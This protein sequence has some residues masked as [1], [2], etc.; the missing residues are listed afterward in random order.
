M[1]VASWLV[2]SP[3]HAQEATDAARL[4]REGWR[5]YRDKQYAEACPLL[6]RSVAAAPKVRARGALALCYQDSGRLATAYQTW[7]VVAGEARAA[8]AAEAASLRLA[9]RAIAR[10]APRLTRAEL[11]VVDA[12][13]QLRV[14]LDGQ[15]LAAAD[16][17]APIL[18]DPGLH[19]LEARAPERVDWQGS[20]E[21]TPADEGKTRS[22]PIG[23]LPPVPRVA[24]VEPAPAETAPAVTAA[25]ARRTPT[26]R[27]VGLATA[28]AGVV[29]LGV[30]TFAALSARSTWNDAKAM[31]CDDSGVCRTQAGVDLVNDASSKATLGTVF[32]SAGL[33]LAAGGA[34]LWFLTP[35]GEPVTPSVAVGPGGA[36]LVVRGSF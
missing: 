36:Q 21:V 11:E 5:L 15:E 6:E 23:P 13:P 16:L 31:G 20:F 12:P 28:G 7:Q 1:S 18:V 26:L 25:P 14:S 29:A 30:G 35:S 24:E 22:V 2:S 34:A 33:A 4:Y 8:G 17:G 27:Y 9:E 10:L 3:A 32:F 19:T